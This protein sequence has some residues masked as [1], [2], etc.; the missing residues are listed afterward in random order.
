MRLESR[1]EVMT[2]QINYMENILEEQSEDL[3]TVMENRTLST[4]QQ[5]SGIAK[6]D[7]AACCNNTSLLGAC[8]MAR[9]VVRLL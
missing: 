7:Y 6:T 9:P 3:K 2:V 8:L 4:R 1:I 5:Q